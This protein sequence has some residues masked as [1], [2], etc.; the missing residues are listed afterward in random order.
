MVGAD[1]G[2]IVAEHPFGIGIDPS[3]AP[4]TGPALR[5]VSRD[6]FTGS[7]GIDELRQ[8]ERQRAALR[9]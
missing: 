8:L 4:A 6:S 1:F 3:A 9:A 7:A 2:A 5:I